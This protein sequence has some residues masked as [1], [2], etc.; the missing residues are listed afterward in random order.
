V[1]RRNFIYNSSIIALSTS[2]FG[3]IKWNGKSFVGSDPTTADILGPYYRPGAPIRTDLA[4][5]GATGDII[6]FSGII[7]GKDGKTPEKN[8]L[9]EIWHCNENGLYDNTSDDY[10]YRASWRTGADGKYDFRTIMPVPYKVSETATRPAHIHMR[11]SGTTDQDLVTQIYFK[12]DKY[13]PSDASSSDPKSINRILD[14]STNSRNEKLVRF[15]VILQDAYLLDAAG[16]KKIEGLYDMGKGMM[17]EFYHDGDDLFIKS[18]GQIEEAMVY[19]G[20]N[21]FEGGLGQFK[22]QFEILPDNVVKVKVTYLDDDNKFVT[23]E[24]TR[25]LKYPD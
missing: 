9:L 18:N 3:K 12:G 24:G 21:S 6:R 20:N 13:I 10:I 11:I 19:K 22:V 1:Q 17:T 23:D 14:V 25:L 8:A 16:F 5:P 2:I 7:F 15:D 4:Q